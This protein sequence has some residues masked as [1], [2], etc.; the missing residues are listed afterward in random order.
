MARLHFGAFY[1]K[2]HFLQ[3]HDLANMHEIISQSI[4]IEI[5]TY[6]RR[7]ALILKQLLTIEARI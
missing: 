3:P 7:Q 1:S 6:M 5:L 4:L 2:R